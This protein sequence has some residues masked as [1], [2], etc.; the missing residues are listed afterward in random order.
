MQ[1]RSERYLK[2]AKAAEREAV[3]AGASEEREAFLKIAATWRQLAEARRGEFEPPTPTP[4]M[5]QTPTIAPNLRTFSQ[6][7]WSTRGRP[8]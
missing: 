4:A 5:V 2:Y 1:D 3:R 7:G 6:T 8:D